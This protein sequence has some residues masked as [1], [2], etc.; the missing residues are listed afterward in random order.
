MNYYNDGNTE[1]YIC[2]ACQRFVLYVNEHRL[3]ERCTQGGRAPAPIYFV[4]YMNEIAPIKPNGEVLGEMGWK[5]IKGRINR[6]YKEVAP[7]D[8]Y[9]WNASVKSKKR[10][11]RRTNPEEG[12]IYLIESENGYYKLGR[13]IDVERRLSQHEMDYP[14]KMWVLHSFKSNNVKKDERKVLNLFADKQLRGEWFNLDGYDVSWFMSI[15]D[16]CLTA[17]FLEFEL[18]YKKLEPYEGKKPKTI[19]GR[20]KSKLGKILEKVS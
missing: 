7:N 13:S 12:Y 4:W 15:E 16:Y 18:K 14:L 19:L 20:L 11:A 5:R 17:A 6:F 10:Q 3:C 2:L 9:I 1:W 8:R